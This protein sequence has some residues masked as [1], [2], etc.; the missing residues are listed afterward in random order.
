MNRRAFLRRAG[1]GAM[2]LYAADAR[3]VAAAAAQRRAPTVR[4]GEFAHGVLSGDPTHRAVTLWTR[5]GGVERDLFRVRLEVARD[6]DFKRVVGS[7]LV[8]VTRA[9]DFTVK[10]RVGRLKP[11]ERY[12]Y[13]FET[14]DE[15][16]PV[17]RLQTAPPPGSEQPVRFAFF[18]CQQYTSGYYGAYR[19]LL[20]QD[21]DFVVC[22]GDY[23]YERRFYLPYREDKTGANGDG[24]VRTLEEYRAKY[25][26]YRS[27]PDLQEMHRRLPF[28]AMWDDHE[29]E[30]N[31]A[32]S[33][34]RTPDGNGPRIAAGHQA[35]HEYQPQL[36]FKERFRTYR[37]FTF[38]R[39][40]ELFLLDERS[41]RDDQ[42]C[43][44]AFAQPCGESAAPRN[45]LGRAQMDW[46]K[47]RLDTS[48]A[49]WKVVGN[50]LMIMP[51]DIA[52]G[53]PLV[54][55]SWEGYQ[56]ER[57]E[58]LAKIERERIEDVVFITGDIH[59][60]FAGEVRRDGRS[61]PPV[62]TEFV[63]GATTTPGVSETAYD[64]AKENGFPVLPPSTPAAT[65]VA[66]QFPL[67]NPWLA[68][69]NTSANGY[70]LVEAGP[71]EL[72]VRYFASRDVKTA[73]G[74]RDVSELARFTVPRGAPR[75]ER[76]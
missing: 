73:E 24:E 9:A 10:V 39:A 63:G 19:H 14:R 50:Q 74:S 17:G 56:A 34:E 5:V 6:P 62:A 42:P 8:P 47:D 37:R 54:Q 26:L 25:R 68:Y 30:D 23:I 40:L 12:W 71:R 18:S 15:V 69:A 75:V 53:Q 52:P 49:Q 60:F 43:G 35:F 45:F 36:R 76:R 22:L 29:V 70:A 67:T 3:L 64:L 2:A 11:D 28:L 31:Y 44:D 21:P 4:G 27:D 48:R 16:S 57:S 38:G 58:L 1:T 59:T 72:G 13:R 61:G 20:E 65:V 55:D 7:R 66:D 51:L 41:Y 32:G 46:L 33:P